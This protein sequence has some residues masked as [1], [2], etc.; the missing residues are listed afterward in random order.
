LALLLISMAG[1]HRK[2]ADFEVADVIVTAPRVSM[3]KLPS[4]AAR[5]APARVM[6]AHVDRR[7]GRTRAEPET[8]D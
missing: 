6:K 7:H 2:D 5:M 3:E 4:G 1:G 8:L